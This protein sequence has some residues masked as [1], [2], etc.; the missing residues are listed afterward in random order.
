MGVRTEKERIQR[1][2]E[3]ISKE[4]RKIG[5]AK[6]ALERDAWWVGSSNFNSFRFLFARFFLKTDENAKKNLQFEKNKDRHRSGRSE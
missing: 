4:G 1:R 3:A 6:S 2:E 5:P